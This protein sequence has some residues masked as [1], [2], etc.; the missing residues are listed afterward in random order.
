MVQLRPAIGIGQT[1]YAGDYACRQFF[2]QIDRI[3]QIQLLHHFLQFPVGKCMQKLLLRVEFQ[4]GKNLRPFGFGQQ[5]KYQRR[6]FRRQ[7]FNKS[8]CIRYMDLRQKLL[9][10][11][12]LLCRKRYL[13]RV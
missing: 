11:G 8:S 9:Q 10:T 7:A 13:Q 5:A 6:F 2:Q 12:I 1:Q 4:F 3:I